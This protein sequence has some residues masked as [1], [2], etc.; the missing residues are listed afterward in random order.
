M[1]GVTSRSKSNKSSN[2]SGNRTG[3]ERHELVRWQY[4]DE[5]QDEAHEHE[6]QQDVQKVS[7]CLGGQEREGGG[8]G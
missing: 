3:H 4:D 8:Q 5:V 1:A 7:V 2:M 6:G